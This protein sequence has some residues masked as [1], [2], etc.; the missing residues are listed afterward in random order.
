MKKIF[1]ALLF[2]IISLIPII[3]IAG[4]GAT[5]WYCAYFNDSQQASG[6]FRY[7]NWIRVSNPND[8]EAKIKISYYNMSGAKFNNTTSFTHIVPAKN[9]LSWTP[10]NDIN[11][12]VP[13][14]LFGSYEIKAIEGSVKVESDMARLSGP[15][16]PDSN[17][18]L[19]QAVSYH[20]I[21]AQTSSSTYL[22][23]DMYTQCD[24]NGD[25]DAT[26]GGEDVTWICLNNPSDTLSAVADIFL[27][28]EAGG[29]PRTNTITILPHQTKAFTPASDP[30]FI[31][32]TTLNS[33][34]RG[35]AVIDVKQGS[36]VGIYN[37]YL[38]DVVN[39]SNLRVFR[40]TGD[41]LHKM[42]PSR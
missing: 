6:N 35:Q 18:V 14:N 11:M 27:Y 23:M 19:D 32:S 22:T 36:L 38:C 25:N 26:V 3:A 1:P 5:D 21:P 24:P 31:N 37:K 28:D 41:S 17:Y 30:Y 8:Y 42:T 34:K 10:N 15:T 39:A 9:T 16:F 7:I 20:T 13:D 12:A 40:A 33:D 2:A 29:T 4:Q